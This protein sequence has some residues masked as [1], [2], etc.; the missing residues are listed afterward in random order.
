MQD[1]ARLLSRETRSRTE[2]LESQAAGRPNGQ[3][4]SQGLSTKS[5]SSLLPGP[6]TDQEDGLCKLTLSTGEEKG[7]SVPHFYHLSFLE[8]IESWNLLGGKIDRAGRQGSPGKFRPPA[9][10]SPTRTHSRVVG[11]GDLPQVVLSPGSNYGKKWSHTAHL[12]H[13]SPEGQAHVL[14]VLLDEEVLDSQEPFEH[15][16]GCVCPRS[17]GGLHFSLSMLQ[18][19]ADQSAPDS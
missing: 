17:D 15:S 1:Y 10:I 16:P 7:P 14:I 19:P 11:A 13:V 9:A 2:S 8:D 4:Q 3:P 12:P 18:Q 5:Y 6:R